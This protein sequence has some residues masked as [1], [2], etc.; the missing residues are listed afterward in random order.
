MAFI[1]DCR[2]ED[3]AL[4]RI[5]SKLPGPYDS[6][7]WSGDYRLRSD[8]ALNGTAEDKEA[9][10]FAGH[11]VRAGRG[12][13]IVDRVYGYTEDDQEAGA[14]TLN[15]ALGSDIA[16]G[17]AIEN[18]DAAAAGITD[19]NFI[20][21]LIDRDGVGPDH[22]CVRSL[23]DANGSVGAIGAAAEDQH[24]IGKG[25]RD[26]DFIMRGIVGDA[27]HGS[28]QTCSLPGDDADRI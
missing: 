9:G 22:L 28:T 3:F 24:G 16:V 20:V 2:D 4:P 6:R 26:V 25:D 15:D 13:S 12:Q 10:F 19:D 14:G 8:V 27:M 21:L 18:E 23:D 11:A 7:F 1:I 17:I 5:G